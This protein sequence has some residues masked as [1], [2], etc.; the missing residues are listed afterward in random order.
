MQEWVNEIH[1]R[2]LNRSGPTERRGE[3]LD[4]GEE[5]EGCCAEGFPE[6]SRREAP[7]VVAVRA[8]V[9]ASG[10]VPVLTA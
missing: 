9:L 7:V 1:F 3:D 10:G 4:V 2:R 8:G 5:G 6:E